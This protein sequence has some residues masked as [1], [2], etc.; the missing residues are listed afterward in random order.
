MAWRYQIPQFLKLGFR[1]VAPDCIGYGRSDAPT[2][3]I[4]P[5]TFKSHADDFHELCKSLGCENVVVGAHD[6]GCMIAYRFALT[7]PSFVTHLFTCAVPYF[8][9]MENFIPT[10]VLV[11]FLPTLGYQLQFGSKEGIIESVTKDKAGIRNFLNALYGGETSDGKVAMT[12]EKGVDLDLMSSLKRSPFVSEDELDYYV[13]EYSRNGLAAPCNY[14][15]NRPANH[16]ADKPLLSV[17]GGLDIKC[18]VLF[19][20]ALGDSIVTDELVN[21]MGEHV[22]NLTLKNVDASHWLLWEK[23]EEVNGLVTEWMRGQ[24]I[25]N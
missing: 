20:R 18:P 6:W 25:V 2:D 11:N 8:A 15:R 17:E 14:Y 22:S 12:A 23:P 9:T 1:V 7:Y 21:K 16:E 5:Y 3:S 24:G 4:V 13:E 10:D 19:V